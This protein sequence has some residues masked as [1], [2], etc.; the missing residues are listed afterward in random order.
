MRGIMVNSWYRWYQ[1]SILR[2][3]REPSGTGVV[4]RIFRTFL[5]AT[6]PWVDGFSSNS[7]FMSMY[8]RVAHL[9]AAICLS[10]AAARLNGA[11]FAATL[12]VL[13]VIEFYGSVAREFPGLLAPDLPAPFSDELARITPDLFQPIAEVP[14]PPPP[15]P[16]PRA[17]AAQDEDVLQVPQVLPV[18]V[19]SLPRP[20]RA[21][22]NGT[23]GKRRTI[24]GALEFKTRNNGQH[25]PWERALQRMDN[26]LP[27]YHF[28]EIEALKCP[29]RFQ[30]WRE[31]VAGLKALKGMALLSAVNARVNGLVGHSTDARVFGARDHWASPLEFLEVGG[32]CE[33]FTLLKYASLLELGID[34]NDLRIV[35]VKDTR[36][37][38]GHAVLAVNTASGEWILDSLDDR[39]RPDSTFQH[40][41]PVYSLNRHQRW[42]HVGFRRITKT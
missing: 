30:K 17:R 34:E 25:R 16:E 3:A 26:E 6:A 41:K 24:F 1:R 22:G 31:M 38:R 33:D 27:L 13:S 40:Y 11:A 19:K 42:L 35:V 15:L 28:C 29:D 12:G 10:R 39:I 21:T 20:V 37:K 9:P 5:Q 32:D 4:S 18:A 7:G 23:A 14:P 36:R 2:V 8:L